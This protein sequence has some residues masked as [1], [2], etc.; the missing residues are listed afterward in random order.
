M[1]GFLAHFLDIPV[2]IVSTPHVAGERGI[3]VLEIG[4][5]TRQAGYS[6]LV[7]IEV[8]GPSGTRSAAGG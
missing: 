5:K 6:A 4:S 1:G 8:S 2:N 3:R 7:R